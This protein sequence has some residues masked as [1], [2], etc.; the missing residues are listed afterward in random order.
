MV[1]WHLDMFVWT[2]LQNPL[3][4]THFNIFVEEGTC[5]NGSPS[6]DDDLEKSGKCPFGSN[7]WQTCQ[8][9]SWI[10][11]A[12]W[13]CLREGLYVR[14]I[15]KLEMSAHSHIFEYTRKNVQISFWTCKLSVTALMMRLLTCKQFVQRFIIRNVR[16]VLLRFVLNEWII[17][18]ITTIWPVI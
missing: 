3:A 8:I 18:L 4:N 17:A 1:L 12:L 10:S 14:T 2:S 6:L 5:A 11:Y 13:Y 9:N 15:N 7:E 16:Y